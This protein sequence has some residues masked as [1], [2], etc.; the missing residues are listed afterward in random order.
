MTVQNYLELT[1]WL[2]FYVLIAAGIGRIY[3]KYYD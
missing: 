2:C 1:F 3:L